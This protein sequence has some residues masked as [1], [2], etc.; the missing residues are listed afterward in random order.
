MLL[1]AQTNA[2]L[3][4]YYSNDYSDDYHLNSEYN[5]DHRRRHQYYSQRESDAI[6]YIS[7]RALGPSLYPHD[8]NAQQTNHQ[9]LEGLLRIPS[10]SVRMPANADCHKSC[11]YLKQVQSAKDALSQYMYLMVCSEGCKKNIECINDNYCL[12]V[13]PENPDYCNYENDYYFTIIYLFIVNPVITCIN[14]C[15]L[16]KIAPKVFKSGRCG[17]K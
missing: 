4:D 5:V 13:M 14:K 7:S 15:E 16:F 3:N 8:S 11:N 10:V 9:M 12:P 17:L 1:T 2:W 6:P